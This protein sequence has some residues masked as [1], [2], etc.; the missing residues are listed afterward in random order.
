MT[1]HS[2]GRSGPRWSATW[3]ERRWWCRVE[4]SREVA[5]AN[6]TFVETQFRASGARAVQGGAA[7]DPGQRRWRCGHLGWCRSRR[8]TGRQARGRR[9]RWFG[10]L[11]RA[12]RRGGRGTGRGARRSGAGHRGGAAGRRAHG[13]DAGPSGRAA[14]RGPGAGR[15]GGRPVT[16]REASALRHAFGGSSCA[17]PNH[18]EAKKP[19]TAAVAAMSRRIPRSCA[20]LFRTTA[21]GHPASRGP[22]ARPT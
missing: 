4:S 22:E 12:C 8:G 15:G 16:S 7:D 1:W 17:Q 21:P 20:L 3:A 18:P 14:R 6:I 11:R 2:S 13:H 9:Y 10:R 5:F 19:K